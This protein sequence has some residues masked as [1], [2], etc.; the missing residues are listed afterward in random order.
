MW[1]KFTAVDNND[2]RKELWINDTAKLACIKDMGANAS[3]LVFESG[4]EV[5][6]EGSPEDVIRELGGAVPDVRTQF[7]AAG[8]EQ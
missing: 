6:V 4:Y 5:R 1:R 7:L 8:E 2:N 3:L